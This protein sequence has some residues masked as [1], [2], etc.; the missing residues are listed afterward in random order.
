MPLTLR[1]EHFAAE[2][3]ITRYDEKID[4]RE[5][6]DV[7]KREKLG[8]AFRRKH[9]LHELLGGNK[10]APTSI[11][12]ALAD[13]V[14]QTRGLT[15][16][17]LG[18]L[19]PT[20]C[21]HT[22]KNPG[23][24]L[25]SK[26]D[27]HTDVDVLILDTHSE[28]NPPPNECGIDWWVRPLGRYPTNGRVWLWY[29]LQLAKGAKTGEKPG[30]ADLPIM[31]GY[32]NGTRYAAINPEFRDIKAAREKRLKAGIID[33]GLYLPDIYTFNSIYRT[34]TDHVRTQYP[35]LLA[36]M[37]KARRRLADLDASNVWNSDKLID[38]SGY[39][40]VVELVDEGY[41]IA[42]PTG[43]PNIWQETRRD[44]MKKCLD[45]EADAICSGISDN[46]KEEISKLLRTKHMNRDYEYLNMHYSEGDDLLYPVLPRKLLTFRPPC[47]P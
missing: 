28:K 21:E 36:H 22:T 41:K 37:D 43:V 42:Y 13:L 30:R 6:F 2:D 34:T 47:N 9:M 17:I 44:I 12:L 26:L 18:S 35:K 5:K 39:S 16:V 29:D 45:S 7:R 23:E 24:D 31:H 27:R 20:L 15:G 40:V 8:Q 32:Y 11:G 10:P 38:R 1:V 14:L 25:F 4:R 46:L 33:P 19:V 3:I